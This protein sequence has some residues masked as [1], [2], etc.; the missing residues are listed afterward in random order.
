M[1][2]QELG[3]LYENS[4]GSIKNCIMLILLENIK[5]SGRPR[6]VIN[7]KS[8]TEVKNLLTLSELKRLPI[9]EILCRDND[10][11]FLKQKTIQNIQ[12]MG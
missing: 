8:I 2:F 1:F 11:K 10:C 3:L 12:K 7:E 5:H 4:F 6:L 9:Y